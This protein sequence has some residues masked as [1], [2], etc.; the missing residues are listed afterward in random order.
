MKKRSNI[1]Y[2]ILLILFLT[3]CT[4]E[5]T[6]FESVDISLKLPADYIRMNTT[7]FK[8]HFQSSEYSDSIVNSRIEKIN[9]LIRIPN[10]AYIQDTTNI[11]NSILIMQTPYLILNKASFKELRKYMAKLLK[12]SHEFDKIE[13]IESNLCQGV[14]PYAKFKYKVF[15]CQ[16]E[17]VVTYYI[18]NKSHTTKIIAIN[19]VDKIDYEETIKYIE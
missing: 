18:L 11:F 12:N 5:H 2:I 19:N 15:I 7:Q 4:D 9:N 3:N 6:R 14:Y 1:Y 10:Y 8:A 17:F 13:R 16:D